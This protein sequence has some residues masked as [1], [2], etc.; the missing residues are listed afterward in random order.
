M[1]HHVKGHAESV[2]PARGCDAG[3]DRHLSGLNPCRFFFGLL[4]LFR[5]AVHLGFL[6]RPV[7]IGILFALILDPDPPFLGIG[8]FFELLWLDLIPAGT[9]IPPQSQLAAFVCAV[10]A[11]LLQVS[12]PARMI[13]LL[14]LAIPVAWLGSRVESAH[15]S[16][17]NAVQDTL[18]H[19]A[20]SREAGEGRDPS[21]F[22]LRSL[23]LYAAIQAGLGLIASLCLYSL[24]ALVL[25]HW[26][27]QSWAGW[28]EIWVGALLGGLL[29]L[30]LK[31]VYVFA[32]ACVVLIFTATWLRGIT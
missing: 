23:G 27:V 10:A 15:R 21:G 9:Y 28:P 14:L 31:R 24:G 30:R 29:A 18:A 8:I 26:P 1:P 16:R 13:P 7:V 25:T 2:K 17:Q 19:L 22:V 6:D 4:S 3:I 32:T 20:S 11:A 5:N 12:D